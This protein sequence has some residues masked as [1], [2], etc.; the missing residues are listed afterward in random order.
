MDEGQEY[1]RSFDKKSEAGAY[2]SSLTTARNTGR[3][4]HDRAGRITIGDLWDQLASQSGH[5]SPKT[6]ASRETAYRV[7]VAPRW[8]A[9]QVG[10]VKV[11]A[12]RSWV[13]QM[14]N[15]G[16][17]VPTIERAVGVLRGI[18]ELAV[19][20]KRVAANPVVNVK[21]PRRE[22][23]DRNYLSVE[24]VDRLAEAVSFRP[25]VVRFLAFTGLRWGEMAAL[26]VRDFD[27][28]RRR[29]DISRSVTEVRGALV[30]GTPKTHERRSV[31][32]PAA[33][34]GD[35]SRLMVGK[36]RDDLVFSSDDNGVLRN[37]NW[38][39]RVWNR[40]LAAVQADD[41]EFPTVSPHDLRHTAASLAISAGANVL[42]LQRMLGHAKASMTLDT[43]SDLFDGDL[44]HVAGA[45]DAK[46]AAS[47]ETTAGPLRDGGVN[48]MNA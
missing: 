39:P 23:A 29:I 43:Y 42:A 30:W 2:L 38:R 10:D 3:F 32:F 36:S 27:M 24:Q 26:R 14:A 9:V 31:P 7:H 20:D 18:C 28:L 6:L 19:D 40:A 21:L 47:R 44:D 1:S 33:L 41:P 45:L 11:T 35:L 4:V 8:V 22:H 25:E 13:T 12:V 34:A 15:D 37:T 48:S 46:I 16:V 5:L 17:G